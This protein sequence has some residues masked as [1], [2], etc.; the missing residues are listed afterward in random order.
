MSRQL[1]QSWWENRSFNT[2]CLDQAVVRIVDIVR[3]SSSYFISDNFVRVFLNRVILMSQWPYRLSKRS[4]WSK[5]VIRLSN[6]FLPWN[7]TVYFG[8]FDKKPVAVKLNPLD[9]KVIYFNAWQDPSS[10]MKNVI[11]VAYVMPHYLY[12][13]IQTRQE[14]NFIG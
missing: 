10:S 2:K 8:Q 13:I 7:R 14:F 5:T 12:T 11:H 6:F 9:Y 4:C 1:I 3:R